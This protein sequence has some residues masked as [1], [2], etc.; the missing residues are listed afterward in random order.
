MDDCD[1]HHGFGIEEV[2]VESIEALNSVGN[3]GGRTSILAQSV[4][5]QGD[6]HLSWP[7]IPCTGWVS[8]GQEMMSRSLWGPH[9][10]HGWI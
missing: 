9:A 2:L 3:F 1:T 10:V 7:K 5:Q 6:T 8:D 4:L